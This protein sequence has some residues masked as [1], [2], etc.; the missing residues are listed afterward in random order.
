MN[1]VTKRRAGTP[2]TSPMERELFGTP[3]KRRRYEQERLIITTTEE[4]LGVMEKA[5]VTR[6]QLA[7]DL[8]ISKAAVGQFLDGETNLT[9]RTLSDIAWALGG[10]LTITFGVPTATTMNRDQEP[11]RIRAV[12]ARLKGK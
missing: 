10:R 6:S 2:A 8:G 7:R 4:I 11:L 1:M 3:A 9:L 12:A 5:E